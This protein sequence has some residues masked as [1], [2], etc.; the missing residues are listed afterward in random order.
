MSLWVE[1][2]ASSANCEKKRNSLD[3]SPFSLC[4]QHLSFETIISLP[5]NQPLFSN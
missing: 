5:F 3:F 1:L 2:R 4:L